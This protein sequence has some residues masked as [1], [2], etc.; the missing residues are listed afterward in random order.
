MTL[1]PE[2]PSPR[3]TDHDAGPVRVIL[4]ADEIQ[5]ALTRMSHQVTELAK[6]AQN[7]LVLGIPTRG[8]PL[9]RRLATE[10]GRIE[11][12]QVPVGDL[13]ITLYRDDLRR[14]PTRTA[15]RSLIP[16]PVE[17]R[18]VLLVDDVLNSGRTVLAAL[19][20]LK[21]IGRPDRVMLATL[22]DRG[23]RELPLQADVVGLQI[24]TA[25]DERVAVHLVEHDG[26]DLVTIQR[27]PAAKGTR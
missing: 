1:N 5:R 21:D 12:G 18:T 2:S 10:I 23:G 25:K 9:S 22:V 6:G 17:G 26:Q 4:Q 27:I 11:G 24:G 3:A 14:N 19:D 7:L 13:D 8:V 16:C 15:G 20:A